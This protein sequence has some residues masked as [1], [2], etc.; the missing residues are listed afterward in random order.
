MSS[1]TP[2]TSGQYSESGGKRDMYEKL[3]ERLQGQS[4]FCM[5]PK[6][7]RSQFTK[8]ALMYCA[9]VY[10]SGIWLVLTDWCKVKSVFTT[11]LRPILSAQ[12][13]D[14]E[15]EISPQVTKWIK[16][17]HKKYKFRTIRQAHVTSWWWRGR[18]QDIRISGCPIFCMWIWQVEMNPGVG[19]LHAR[20]N[21]W[22]A[23]PWLW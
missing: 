13:K 21:M 19:N 14:G 10:R 6:T 3:E 12:L 15:R 9:H 8:L 4:S 20:N 7:H 17:Q 23:S 2:T 11:N 22:T 18:R 16:G 5:T 1:H